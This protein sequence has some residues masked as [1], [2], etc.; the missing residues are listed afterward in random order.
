MELIEQTEETKRADKSLA[1][2]IITSVILSGVFGWGYLIGISFVA[3]N[4]PYLLSSD[5]DAAG[6]AIAEIFNLA[7]KNRYGSGVGELFV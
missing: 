3:T 7:F 2:G 5:N 1:I 6:Y 4:I